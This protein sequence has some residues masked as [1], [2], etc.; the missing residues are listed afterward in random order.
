[1]GQW[2]HNFM[3]SFV[4]RFLHVSRFTFHVLRFIPRHI[5]PNVLALFLVF[6][7]GGV[8]IWVL[9]ENPVEVYLILWSS[10]FGSIDDF[11]YVLFNA[12]PL[13]F[14]GLAVTIGFKCGLFNVG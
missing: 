10:V 4:H 8:L 1:M 3:S 13:I 2:V 6:L 11:G 14:T 5:L 7:L 12:T 9:G